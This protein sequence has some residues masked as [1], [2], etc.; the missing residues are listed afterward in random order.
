MVKSL[1]S[2]ATILSETTR[3]DGDRR[4]SHDTD[5][6]PDTTGRPWEPPPVKTGTERRRQPTDHRGVDT[7]QSDAAS[8]AAQPPEIVDQPDDEQHWHDRRQHCQHRPR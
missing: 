8:H 7:Q 1:T 4:D 5:E 6:V 2:T 3:A